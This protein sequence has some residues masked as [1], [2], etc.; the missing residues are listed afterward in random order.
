MVKSTKYSIPYQIFTVLAGALLMGFM[1]RVRGTHGWGSSWGLLAAGF[2]FTMFITMIKGQ[3]EKLNFGKLAIVALSFML[4]TPAWGT[5]LGQITGVIFQAEDIV[6]LIPLNGAYANDVYCS[7]P[8]AIYIMLSL[9]FGLASLFGIMLGQCYSEKQWKLKD[10]IILLAVFFAV[11]LIGKATLPH[12]ILDIIQPQAVEVF[13][14]GCKLKGIEGSAWQVYMQHFDD[15]SWAK[16]IIGGR[17]Y[18]QS[19][20]MITYAMKSV[21]VLIATRFIIK[22][23]RA[24]TTGFIVCGAF[25]FSITVSDLFFY[26]GDGG[27]HMLGEN[28]FGDNVAPWSC[29]EYFTGFIAG[30]I[31]TAHMLGI[32]SEADAPEIKFA[33]IPEKVT[34]IL[35]FLLGYI[36]LI[37]VNIVRPVLERYDESK[38]QILYVVISVLVAVALV[39]VL[40]KKWGFAAEKTNM[41]KVSSTLLPLFMALIFLSYMFLS[42]ESYRNYTSLTMVHNLLVVISLLAV[43]AWCGIHTKKYLTK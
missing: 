26:F 23:K 7:V 27:Y 25:A 24:A 37:G 6:D 17:N 31:I 18:F 15:V 4:T 41:V 19:V 42:S 13:E 33:K 38:L 32:K 29:W 11:D 43:V 21:A 8:S 14:A 2:M 10:Y 30:G 9:G 22:D 35:T 1:W 3:R 36:F 34:N 28:L 40:V 16:K 12:L 5:L 20:E 39:A